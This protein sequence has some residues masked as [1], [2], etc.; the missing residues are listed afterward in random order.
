MHPKDPNDI[1][2]VLSGTGSSHIYRS[3]NAGIATPTFT[4]LAGTGAGALPDIPANCV[5]RMPD[6]P[7]TDFFVGT[8]IGVFYTSNGGVSWQNVGAPLG[9]PK[10]EVTAMKATPGTG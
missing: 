9:L 2:L 1:T 7:T 10:S 6:R 4:S 8:D 3:V 5:E